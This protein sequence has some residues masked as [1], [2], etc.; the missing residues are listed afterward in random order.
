MTKLSRTLVLSIAATGVVMA[1]DAQ[2]GKAA[3]DKSC[4]SCHGAAGTPNPPIAKALK[5]EMRD[6]ASK[7]VQALSDAELKAI[8][9]DGKG[10]MKPIKTVAGPEAD[11]VIADA[12]V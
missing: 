11:N 10:K 3:Y 12:D 7:E 6:L 5:V 4:K 8:V 2:A 1:A 9:T